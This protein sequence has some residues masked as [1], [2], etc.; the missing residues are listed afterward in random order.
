ML[1]RFRFCVLNLLVLPSLIFMIGCG[2]STPGMGPGGASGN[3]PLGGGLPAGHPG[4]SALESNGKATN[5]DIFP[6]IE[7]ELTIKSIEPQPPADTGSRRI[8][9]NIKSDVRNNVCID[10]SGNL[11]N[12]PLDFQIWDLSPNETV[13]EWI[14]RGPVSVDTTVF[15]KSLPQRVRTLLIMDRNAAYARTISSVQ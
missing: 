5:N 6:Q 8:R 3:V 9:F 1:S 7:C 11:V 12:T 15:Q 13:K 2:S 14:D 10:S 4:N